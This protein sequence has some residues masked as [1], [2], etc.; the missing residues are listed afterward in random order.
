[1]ATTHFA[2]IDN[3]SNATLAKLPLTIPINPTVDGFEQAGYDVRWTWA[4]E[5]IEC[6]NHGGS[7]DCTPFCNLCQGNQETEIN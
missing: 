7:F 6:P 2:I 5:T 3:G 4:D 1:M